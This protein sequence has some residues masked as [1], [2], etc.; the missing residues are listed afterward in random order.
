VRGEAAAAAERAVVASL[1]TGRAAWWAALVSVVVTR[2]AVAAKV[3][4]RW[5]AARVVVARTV[6]AV[7]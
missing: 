7:V 5:V 1:A 3:A 4:A 6:A 2:W